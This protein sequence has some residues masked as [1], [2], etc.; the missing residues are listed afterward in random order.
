[1]GCAVTVDPAF[2]D[3]HLIEIRRVGV[4][5]CLDHEGGRAR[6][7][8]QFAAHWDAIT[9]SDGLEVG[10]VNALWRI[11]PATEEPKHDPRACRG[12]DLAPLHA[13]E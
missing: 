6:T 7:L 3:L 5:H 8:R 11:V 4:L 9:V 2:D 10:A 1:M 12:I 13:G